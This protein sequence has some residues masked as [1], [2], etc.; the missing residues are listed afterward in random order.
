MMRA[1]QR[2]RMVA[3]SVAVVLLP[4]L[5]GFVGCLDSHFR[6]VSAAIRHVGQFFT[7]GRIENGKG[8]S[9]I[10]PYPVNE[11]FRFEK[12]VLFESVV[13]GT[14]VSLL[15]VHQIFSVES[16]DTPAWIL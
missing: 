5:K 7:S 16:K 13:K 12:F 6:L 2:F 10:D 15:I 8:F 11:C 1:Y 14:H 3:R 4:A 9:R